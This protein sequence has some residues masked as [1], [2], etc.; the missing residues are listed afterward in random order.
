MKCATFVRLLLGMGLVAGGGAAAAP[1]GPPPLRGS[2]PPQFT[3]DLAISLDDEDQPVLSVAVAVPYD[4]LQWRLLSP[5]Y[6]AGLEV[7]VSLEPPRRGERVFGGTWTRRI[8]VATFQETAGPRMVR[9]NR[10]FRVPPGQ[11]RARVSVRDLASGLSSSA[12]ERLRVPD[13]SQVSLGLSDLSLGTAD[14]AGARGSSTGSTIKS[15]LPRR[16]GD[17]RVAQT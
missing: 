4:G 8:A 7:M 5:G 17:S 10:A 2:A 1:E 14:S 15:R 9:E 13:L 11:Y 16:S 12:A 3:A 6:G